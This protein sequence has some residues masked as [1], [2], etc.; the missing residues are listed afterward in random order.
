MPYKKRSTKSAIRKTN[1]A[2]TFVVG[3]VDYVHPNYAYILRQGEASDIWVK[4]EDLLGALDK[5]TVKVEIL[6][7][8]KA[9]RPV[10]RVVTII[11]RSQAPIVGRL[12]SHGKAAFVVPDGRRMHY[13]IFVQ[14]KGRRGA[15]DGDKVIM[16]I[17]GW[18]NG[19]KNPTG[20]VKKVLGPAGVHEVEM[21]AIMA[22]FALPTQFP[23]KVLTEARAMATTIPATEIMRRKDFRPVLTCTIDPEDAKDFDDALS[24]RVLPNGHYEVGI[25]IA[26]VSHYVSEGSLLDHEA[27]E[28]GTSVYLVDR[29]IPM[30]PEKLSNE[31]C[32]LRP[33]EDKLA[34]SAVF[35]LD[36]QGN[37]HQ[38]WFG[39]TVIHSDKRFTYEEAQESI[40]QRQGDF[41]EAL[42]TLNQLAQQLRRIRFQRGA[43]SF[44][45][46]EVKFRLDEHGK[47]LSVVPK[48][49]KDTH[50]LVEEF[51]LLA[52]QQV[53]SH[54][55]C[56]KHDRTGPLF[57]YR[58]HDSPDPEKLA[59]FFLFAKQLGYQ[60]PA[61]SKA[62]ARALNAITAAVEGTAAAHIVQS[63]AIRTM[64]KAVY[65]TEAKPHF[66]LAF[67][68]YTHFTSPIRRYPDVMVHRLLKQYLQG[69]T[70]TAA[71]IFEKK[72]QH[73]SE[74]ERIAAGAERASVRYKQV[75][76]M[77]TLQGEVLEG[78]IGSIMDWG[79][80]V[81]LLT[82]QCEG[83]VR[84]AELQDDYYEVDSKGFQVLGRR[85]KKTYRLGDRVQ[86]RVKA[87]DLTQ[88]TVDLEM[89]S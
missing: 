76:L 40:D 2:P 10:G 47:P 69:G 11:E 75:E 5:D 6:P 15:K 56:M 26:D 63:L 34:F 17:T 48:V 74:R 59:D 61:G 19:Q 23:K 78:V 87:C 44:E 38:Q 39:E 12:E 84:L 9:G 64:A 82:N 20:V 79:I 43:I 46:T 53:A 25:H 14:P 33:H 51:M 81:E 36:A 55:A 35:A 85:S 67:Q 4:H 88:R 29:T 62:P 57:V 32:S 77:Q 21:H 52:N 7:Q 68:H 73:T 37:V 86:V 60:A 66:G 42:I 49:R 16:A 13:D 28:R 27:L 70:P 41:C 1:L 45:T 18:P 8:R 65:T 71:H 89:V 54:V 31:L 83:M 72:C 50:K 80:Y 22:E 30:L 24:L 3:Q 58:I